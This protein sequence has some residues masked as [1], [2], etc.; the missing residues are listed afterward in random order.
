MCADVIRYGACATACG[1]GVAAENETTVSVTKTGDGISTNPYKIGNYSQLLEFADLV[2]GGQTSICAVL[3]ADI[4]TGNNI[5]INADGAVTT[6]PE[7]QWTPIGSTGKAYTG[8]FDGQGYAIK[9]LYYDGSTM[10]VGLFGLVGSGGKVMNVG[11]VD[12]YFRN[13]SSISSVYTGGVCG[14]SNGS[15]ENCY[16]TGTVCGKKGSVGG[17]CGCNGNIITNC[18]NSGK[19]VGEGTNTGGVCG[20]NSAG[21]NI[22]NCYNT[23]KV[24]GG[25]NVG[26]VC[27]NNSGIISTC[28]YLT[29]CVENPR[30][31]FVS[32]VTK[33]SAKQFES[34]EVAWQLNGNTLECGAGDVPADATNWKWYQKLGE[35]GD[36][37]PVLKKNG[38][39]HIVYASKRCFVVYGWSN[40]KPGT[41]S[42][43]H[44]V[45]EGAEPVPSDAPDEGISHRNLFSYIKPC[46]NSGCSGSPVEEKKNEKVIKWLNDGSD[47]ESKY[48]K[49]SRENDSAPWKT[50]AEITLY[51]DYN[52]NHFWAPVPFMAKSAGYTRQFPSGCYWTTLCLPY[53]ISTTGYQCKFYG[54]LSVDTDKITL[55]ELTGTE[56]AAG[57]PVFVKANIAGAMITFTT[58]DTEMIQEP[59]EPAGSGDRLTG[60]FNRVSLSESKK[61]NHMFIKQDKMWT[62]EATGKTSMKVKPF[63]AYIVPAETSSNTAP[64]RSI[65]IDGEATAISD[66]LDTLNDANAEYYDMSGRRINSLQKGV[67]IIRSGNKTRKVII[68]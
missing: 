52:D 68:K 63:R 32:G 13:K 48:I 53:K 2:N 42:I 17:V 18:Y 34:G 47:D 30:D 35:G 24:A 25:T 49:I 4:N 6:T 57:T 51:D 46:N 10:Y 36:K 11:V 29:D 58:Q 55:K 22:N 26:G 21:N 65:V 7:N 38:E 15:I 27:G 23:G 62:V 16:N 33:K 45:D 64:Q 43:E 61:G 54:L 39:N 31:L 67:N 59:I 19:I 1:G 5:T 9:G 20:A 40:T 14:L 66:A 3:T 50:D 56:V 44:N 28:Y 41:L 37:S 12:S 8:T 60:T